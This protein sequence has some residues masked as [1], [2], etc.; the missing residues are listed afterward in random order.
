M[1][2]GQGSAKGFGSWQDLLSQLPGLFPAERV[3][4]PRKAARGDN[5]GNVKRGNTGVAG[6]PWLRKISGKEG[7][8]DNS[9]T[10]ALPTAICF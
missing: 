2:A 7:Y 10:Y 6:L 9:E 8:M 1:A 5:G 3:G 4:G